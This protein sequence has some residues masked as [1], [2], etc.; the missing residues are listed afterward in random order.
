MEFSVKCGIM[1]E[2]G[3]CP[4]TSPVSRFPS[5]VWLHCWLKQENFP[6]LSVE[7]HFQKSL[8]DQRL[9]VEIYEWDSIRASYVRMGH[10][11]GSVFVDKF[12]QCA[13]LVFLTLSHL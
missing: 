4:A 9:T 13:S 1:H 6:L 10:L 11:V 2:C 7:I 3:T 5:V 12:A 8:V